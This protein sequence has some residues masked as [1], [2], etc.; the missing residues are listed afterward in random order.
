M[1]ETN[2]LRKNVKVLID[3]APY[4]VLDAEHVK[5]GKGNAFTRCK[6]RNLKTGQ[7]LERTF[8][9]GEKFEV[10]DIMSREMQ[11]LF[12]DG[13]LLTF[14]DNETFD[15]VTVNSELIGD[16]MK[17]MKENIVCSVLFFQERPINIELPMFVELPITYCEPGFKGD[18]ATGASKPATLE[19]GHVVSVPLHLSEGDILKIDTRTGDYVEKV[20]R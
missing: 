15:Q 8:K 5:P 6:L 12:Q 17:F 14:M 1:I 19:G 13:V 11:F 2:E 20:N 10:P 18:T 16:Q 3:S 9:N 7:L 4:V